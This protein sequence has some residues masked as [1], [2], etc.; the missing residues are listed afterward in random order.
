MLWQLLHATSLIACLPEVQKARLRLPLWQLRH[1]AACA[2]AGLP[3]AKGLAGLA[4]SGSLRCSEASPWH[5]WH[6]LPLASFLAPCPVRSIECH[7]SSW[8][9]AHIGLVCAWIAGSCACAMAMDEMPAAS[10]KPTT[11][12]A[13]ETVNRMTS[14][15]P[16]GTIRAV[17][18]EEGLRTRSRR[19]N[20]L[21]SAHRTSFE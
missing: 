2:A 9:L 14:S 6:M 7:L 12:V 1:T 4:L 20:V 11:L 21:G 15:L 5:A 17:R 16:Q 13:M 8:Q 18:T 3:C 10:K 19:S